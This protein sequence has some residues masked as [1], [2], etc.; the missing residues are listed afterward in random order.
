MIQD[1]SLHAYALATQHLG[2]KQ[3]TVLDALR[4]FPDATNA[5]LATYL[6]WPVNRI[7]PRVF[8]LRKV[9]LILESGRRPCK[10]T[11]GS[12]HAW[13]AKHPVLPPAFPEAINRE[14]HRQL[15]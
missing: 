14:D 1:T 5:E 3:K 4:F 9:G 11:G 10:A 6:Q 2:A 12:A 13:R 7:T 15:F 8:E